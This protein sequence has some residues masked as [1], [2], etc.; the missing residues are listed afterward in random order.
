ML[1]V[2]LSGLCWRAAAVWSWTAGTGQKVSRR[3]TTATHSPLRSSSK[4]PSKPSSSMPL[5]CV[6]YP[7]IS[8]SKMFV[9]F[10]LLF[11]LSDVRLP[12]YPLLGEP[13]QR[14]AAG[15]HGPTHELHPG[16]CPR[17]LPPGGWHAQR[18]SISRGMYRIYWYHFTLVWSYSIFYVKRSYSR[19]FLASL[20]PCVCASRSWRESS[21]SKERG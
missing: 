7:L 3:S 6:Y 21:W 16:Q 10:W 19:C 11:V 5:R 13:L 12:G 15:S 20:W 8:L 14:G 17:H 18:L 1:A 4:M 2:P 9:L